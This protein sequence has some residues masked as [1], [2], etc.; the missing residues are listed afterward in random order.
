MF[1]PWLKID[2]VRSKRGAGEEQPEPI[3]SES[4]APLPSA[5]PPA[6]RPPPLKRPASMAPR[7][8]L[9]SKPA[10]LADKH[11]RS[12]SGN[13]VEH[14]AH[15][16]AANAANATTG[17]GVSTTGKTLSMRKPAARASTGSALNATHSQ[18][19]KKLAP[20][21]TAA[22]LAAQPGASS[23]AR[24]HTFANSIPE[25]SKA[26]AA[27]AGANGNARA[28]S[29]AGHRPRGASNDFANRN[30]S[31]SRNRNAPQRL[32]SG[33]SN[34]TLSGTTS[35]AAT[36]GAA[37]ASPERA[38]SRT[39]SRGMSMDKVDGG[40]A[41]GAFKSYSVKGPARN[42][43]NPTSAQAQKPPPSRIPSLSAKKL[44]ASK[45]AHVVDLQSSAS[46]SPAKVLKMTKV[47]LAAAN[48]GSAG[49]LSSAQ[50]QSQPQLA[51]DTTFAS[52]DSG[53]VKPSSSQLQT[54]RSDDLPLPALA[55][56][57]APTEYAELLQP[58]QPETLTD[59]DATAAQPQEADA[60]ASVDEEF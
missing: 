10:A 41:N 20:A 38:R 8:N 57:Q 44:P 35:S 19:V 55:G 48:T 6:A 2:G 29:A 49:S 51:V 26:T 36:G 23:L 60:S 7:S 25:P 31:P 11:K 22:S 54:P 4:A 40:G 15:S 12:S 47:D 45:P 28:A 14:S 16:A 9:N 53:S 52:F 24:A 13:A 17:A 18:S 33:T 56:S 43:N 59:D 27:A 3:D 34:A 1:C 32:S 39:R 50:S 42:S 37:A 5:L 58:L 21:G 30:A 46:R